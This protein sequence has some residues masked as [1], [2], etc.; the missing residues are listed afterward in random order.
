M[1]DVGSLASEFQDTLVAGCDECWRACRYNP[2]Y[3]RRLVLQHGG[4]AAAKQLIRS[5]QPSEGLARLWECRRLDLSMEAE[6]LQP[7]WR[8]LFTEDELAVAR[9][10][11]AELGYDPSG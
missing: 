7:R 11:L 8:L 6:M 3:F 5:E 9:R 10:R 1:T 4:V 2:S